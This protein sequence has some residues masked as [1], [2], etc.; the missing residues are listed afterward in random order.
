M[1]H[2]GLGQLRRS[3][4]LNDQ[5]NRPRGSGFGAFVKGDRITHPSQIEV[6]D[7]LLAQQCDAKNVVRVTRTEFPGENPP[8][9]L[10][11]WGIF[12]DPADPRRVR[13]SGDEEFCVWDFEIGLADDGQTRILAPEFW[14][15]LAKPGKEH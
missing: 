11:F 15:A 4:T 10:K 9:G 6:G 1:A 3:N 12:V 2:L 7:L 8:I 14:Y 13:M 5:P